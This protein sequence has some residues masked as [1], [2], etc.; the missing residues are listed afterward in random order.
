MDATSINGVCVCVC[1]NAMTGF[2]L[3]GLDFVFT[4]QQ[5]IAVKR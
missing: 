2:K 5:W 4:E 3:C 1:F